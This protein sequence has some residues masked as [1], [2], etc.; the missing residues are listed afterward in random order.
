MDREFVER[1]LE[2]V[3]RIPVARAVSYGAIAEHLAAGYGPRYVGRVMATDGYAVPWWRVVRADGAM[4]PPLM[5][6]AQVHW[7]EEG[8]PVRNGRVDVKRAF[9]DFAG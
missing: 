9:W 1:V 7:L 5:A 3:E 2:L 6:E 8:T 4:A